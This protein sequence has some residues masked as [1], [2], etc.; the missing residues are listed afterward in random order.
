MATA[1][2]I[3]V[4]KRGW[5]PSLL[6]GTF[7]T[8]S[9]CFSLVVSLSLSV[10]YTGS[11]FYPFSADDASSDHFKVEANPSAVIP[12]EQPPLGTRPVKSSPVTMPYF[13]M[14][15]PEPEECTEPYWAIRNTKLANHIDSPTSNN[16]ANPVRLYIQTSASAKKYVSIVSLFCFL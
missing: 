4:L 14:T 7:I 10:D 15:S 2:Q 3:G 6:L 1:N 16:S 13:G 11:F 9:S 12:S 8:C 5:R